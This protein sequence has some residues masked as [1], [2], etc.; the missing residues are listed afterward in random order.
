MS[1]MIDRDAAIAA[2]NAR[3]DRA[4]VALAAQ[5]EADAGIIV[6]MKGH[7]WEENPAIHPYDK[8]YIAACDAAISRICMQPH[9]TTAL[10]RIIAATRAKA[11]REALVLVRSYLDAWD[12]ATV[13][14]SSISIICDAIE[15]LIPT[16]PAVS[17]DV[18]AL[19]A[20]VPTTAAYRDV[21]ME[22]SRQ[23]VVEGWTLAHDDE[24]D[25]AEMATAAACYAL[26]ASGWDRTALWEIWPKSWGVDWFKPNYTS[27]R[28]DL[29][30]AAA[31]I[32]AEIERLDRA[33]L[34]KMRVG[35]S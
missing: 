16:P 11:L 4:E 14:G 31:L 32:I 28:R 9:D 35:Q 6:A 19:V 15:A 7:G 26:S 5:I 10:D 33:A 17:D 22:R 29:V 30:K 1:N 27:P 8:G 24:H 20:A 21:L 2:A 23:C 25:G 34:A 3:A 18:A 12:D 13:N